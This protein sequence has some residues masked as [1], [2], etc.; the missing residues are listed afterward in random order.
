MIAFFGSSQFS[1]Y[2]LERLIDVHNISIDLIVTV[3]DKPKGRKLVMTPPPIKEWAEARKIRVF[4]PSSLKFEGSCYQDILSTLQ[5][6]DL[7]IV[8]SYGKIIPQ[9]VIDLPTYTTINIHPSMLPKYRGAS[10]LQYQIKNDEKEI[11][12][13]IIQMDKEVDQGPILAQ[14]LLSEEIRSTLPLSFFDLEKIT[15]EQGADLISTIHKD[16]VNGHLKAAA[17]DHD[18]ATFTQMIEKDEAKI[19]LTDNPYQN[20]LKYLAFIEWPRVFFTV[21]SKG[22][23]MRAIVTDAAFENNSFVIKK[24]IPEGGKE[25]SYQDFERG[26][27]PEIIS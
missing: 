11:G 6:Y 7:F 22:K 19:N 13:T 26:Y 8:A 3:P 17:Q 9:Y 27:S 1:I 5:G 18:K 4:Q 25:M 23:E 2:A 15:A 24:V 21:I 10:P 16:L 14:Q 12:T 20:Y